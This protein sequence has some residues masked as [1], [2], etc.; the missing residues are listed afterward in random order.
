MLLFVRVIAPLIGLL[1][2]L[3]TFLS[4]VRVPWIPPAM[5]P[6]LLFV[7]YLLYYPQTILFLRP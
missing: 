3:A 6:A 5:I 1:I 4:R 7:E 2:E